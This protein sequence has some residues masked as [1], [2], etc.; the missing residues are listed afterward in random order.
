M[1]LDEI[2]RKILKFV[3]VNGSATHAEIA[4]AVPLSASQIQRRVKR[5]EDEK[6]ISGYV[7]IV[8]RA[9]LGYRVSAFTSVSLRNQKGD[10]AEKFHAEIAKISSVTECVIVSG[11]S[12]YMLRII[13][14]D[15]ES[16]SHVIRSELLA[17]P[18][19]EH[20]SSQIIF[21][22]VKSETAVPV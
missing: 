3:Q 21:E 4:H 17:L 12:D 18:M 20:V 8:D 2:D 9:K 1:S 5:L 11:A 22:T 6:I 15:L 13:A 10:D 14:P 16:L 19:V 7:A